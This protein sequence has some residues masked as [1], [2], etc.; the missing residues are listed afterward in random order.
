VKPA[1]KRPEE[2]NRKQILAATDY[3]NVDR[4]TSEFQEVTGK[5]IQY[6]QVTPEQYKSFL[7]API[8]EEML[9]NHLF[10]EEPGYYKGASLKESLSALEDAPT[11][12]KEY[13]A[14]NFQID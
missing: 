3:Y 4:I 14:K 1:L 2:F 10:I 12:W 13:V 6:V 8:A 11:T 5:S 9:E 7:P